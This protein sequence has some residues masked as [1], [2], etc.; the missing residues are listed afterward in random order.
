MSAQTDSR[1]EQPLPKG[2]VARPILLALRRRAHARQRDGVPRRAVVAPVP[3]RLRG[4]S[5]YA[6]LV[7][8]IMRNFMVFY[9]ERN[10]IRR[11]PV[12]LIVFQVI[13]TVFHGVLGSLALPATLLGQTLFARPISPGGR[14]TAHSEALKNAC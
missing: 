6:T 9:V 11:L 3:L 13:R 5:L 8:H 4:Q 1:H 2:A 14:R 12:C 10:G 7:A